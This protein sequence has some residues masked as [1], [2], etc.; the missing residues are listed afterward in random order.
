MYA[1]VYMGEAAGAARGFQGEAQALRTLVIHPPYA[2]RLQ[3]AMAPMHYLSGNLNHFWR[4]FPLKFGTLTLA[5]AIRRI[6]G[7]IGRARSIFDLCR[8]CPAQTIQIG[9]GKVF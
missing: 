6:W 7:G 1:Y 9:C 5:I 3:T 8:T 4:R 2:H